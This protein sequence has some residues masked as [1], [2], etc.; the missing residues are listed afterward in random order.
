ME[1]E[2]VV[3][4]LGNPEKKYQDTL[5]NVGFKVVDHVAKRFG[6]NWVIEKKFQA[7][8]CRGVLEQVSYHLLKPITYMNLSGI[9]L[10]SYLDYY[11]LS[12]ENVLVVFDDADLPLAKLKINP[13]GGSSGHNGLK[14]IEE[15]LGS[16]FYKRLR[17]GVGRSEQ[18]QVTL[19]DY[20]LM[21]QPE[22]IWRLLEKPIEY[23][24]ELIQRL[25]KEDF[26]SV[27]KAANT[28]KKDLH[29]EINE[30]RKEKPL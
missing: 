24:S 20:V 7:A 17:I 25:A 2:L 18:P 16:T 4:G 9:A 14:S 29:G 6:W 8:V 3:V 10:K 21:Q 13:Q 27:M 1:Q 28:A 30:G 19:A 12:K 11:K 5:H 22:T 26:E 23:A 15:A